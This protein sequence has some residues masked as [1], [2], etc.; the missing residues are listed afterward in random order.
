MFAKLS[1]RNIAQ[2]CSPCKTSKND[3]PKLRT[4]NGSKIRMLKQATIVNK[5]DYLVKP[6]KITPSKVDQSCYKFAQ[7]EKELID[8]I[9]LMASQLR[10]AFQA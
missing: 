8:L 2:K 9:P 1:Q 7:S 4:H 6:E 5:H 10:L 3:Y